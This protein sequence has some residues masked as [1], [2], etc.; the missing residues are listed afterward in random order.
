MDET[1]TKRIRYGTPFNGIYHDLD[2]G[3]TGLGPD[4][5]ATHYEG[6]IA[7]MPEC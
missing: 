3:L 7:L 1:V 6:A 2:G 4:T 5:W